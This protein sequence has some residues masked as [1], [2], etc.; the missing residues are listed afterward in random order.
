M[1]RIVVTVEGAPGG[2]LAHAPSVAV[3]SAS[4]P[5]LDRLMSYMAAAY[6]TDEDGAPRTPDQMVAEMVAAFAARLFAD[7]RRQE[8]EAAATA[9]SAAVAPVDFTIT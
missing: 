8:Q 2:P 5:D 9:A 3:E 1:A 7:V 6:G 4:D